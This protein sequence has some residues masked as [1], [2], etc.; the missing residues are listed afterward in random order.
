MTWCHI[1]E[2]S[3]RRGRDIT[4]DCAHIGVRYS[5]PTD[6]RRQIGYERWFKRC[7][8]GRGLKKLHC[9]SRGFVAFE[10]HVYRSKLHAMLQRATYQRFFSNII[11]AAYPNALFVTNNEADD[12]EEMLRDAE[13]LL[14]GDP[15][16]L[17]HS[18]SPTGVRSDLTPERVRLR[19]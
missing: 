7:E 6:Q 9:A 10:T 3:M 14:S 18:G 1:P 5:P 2:S 16:D 12:S 17:I 15:G 11:L 4:K 19:V 8:R 13:P